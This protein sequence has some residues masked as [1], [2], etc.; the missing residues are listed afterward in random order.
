MCEVRQFYYVSFFLLI[1]HFVFVK[2]HISFFA[3]YIITIFIQHYYIFRIFPPPLIQHVIM[4]L[5]RNL[6]PSLKFV[7][8]YILIAICYAMCILHLS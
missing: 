6:N 3:D 1:L 2:H 7:Q 5:D 4:G 8:K